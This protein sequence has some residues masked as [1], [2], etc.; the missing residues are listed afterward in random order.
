MENVRRSQDSR[1]SMKAMQNQRTFKAKETMTDDSL[2]E[3]L[4]K[5]RSDLSANVAK[6]F[7]NQ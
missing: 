6:D 2:I 4:L 3:D 7:I 5:T 1:Y